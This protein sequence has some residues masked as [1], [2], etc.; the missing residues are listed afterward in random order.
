MDRSNSIQNP[1]VA[2]YKLVKD[3]NGAKVDKTYFKQ[4]VGSMRYLTATRLDVM[5]VV[6]L[7]S[8]YMEN[9]IELHLQIAKRVLRYLK[10]T[11][12]FGFFFKN[13]GN[14]E[15]IVYTDSDYDGDLEDR[16]SPPG[17]FF[18]FCWV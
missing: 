4:I 15:L 11:L 8:R 17:Y 18:F 5:I 14:N 2:S 3:E 9:H 6:G 7:I 10:W 1:I 13:G 16:K 12:H